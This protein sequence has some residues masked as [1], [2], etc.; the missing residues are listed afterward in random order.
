M[1]KKLIVAL[2]II[3]VVVGAIFAWRIAYKMQ[4][5][6]DN[7][8]TLSMISEMDNADFLVGYRSN[9]LITVW[10][11]PD[12]TTPT[13]IG[14]TLFAWQIDDETALIVHVD[15]K[16]KVAAYELKKRLKSEYKQIPI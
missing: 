6:T 3:A 4:K 12:T 1:K 5:N 15:N 7:L 13:T 8:P 16:E 9:Q 2:V 14:T 10:G 11:E